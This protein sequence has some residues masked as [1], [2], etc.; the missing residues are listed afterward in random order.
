M[1]H[2][3]AH[4]K[5]QKK[6]RKAS[7]T[8]RRLG[9][10]S[11]QKKE[12][13][14][15]IPKASQKINLIGK[16]L[17]IIKYEDIGELSGGGRI[18]D[19]WAMNQMLAYYEKFRTGKSKL[20]KGY[21]FHDH[22]FLLKYY[23]LKSWEFG[24]WVTQEDRM[25]YVAATGI[26]LYDMKKVLRFTN[27]K[28]GLYGMLGIAN[29]A[30]GHSRAKAHFEPNT[31]VIN[32]TRYKYKVDTLMGKVKVPKDWSFFHT[33]GPGSFA[34]EYGH[35]L[36][37]FFGGYVDQDKDHFA[38]TQGDRT[39]TKP[40]A[41]LMKENSMRG[42]TERLLHTMIWAKVGEQTGYYKKLKERVEEKKLSSYWIR[43]N[44]LFARAFE[45]Y[46]GYQLKQKG[47]ENSFLHKAKYE[48]WV[49][50]DQ[51]LLKK[52]IPHFDTLMKAMRQAKV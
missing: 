35:A 13:A 30:R 18:D 42:I 37:Y 7:S 3:K 41:A 49:Y 40:D 2:E 51:L 20:P 32:M 22:R 8:R 26:S 19:H 52:V 11:T 36:D 34:H 50:M 17:S 47:I 1:K 27:E 45:Q 31:F 39:R 24:N 6:R 14:E 25:N 15:V 43:R 33:G 9:S 10:S 38:L 28:M 4:S 23:G 46:I 16:P 29:G 12:T 48:H 5:T 44:E 21:K